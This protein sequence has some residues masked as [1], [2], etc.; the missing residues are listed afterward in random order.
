MDAPPPPVPPARPGGHQLRREVVLHHQRERILTAAVELIAERGYRAV[1]VADIVKRAA[2]ARAKFYAN[3]ASKQDCFFAAYDRALAEALHRVGE[4]SASAS[5][6]PAGVSAGL[7]ALLGYI[8][9]EPA[10]ARACLL[11]APSL[12]PAMATR[13]EAAQQGFAAL[14]RGGREAAVEAELPG[15][16]EESV[17]GGLYWLLYHAILAAQ[18]ERIEELRPEL[19]EFALTPFLGV[20]AAR[21]AAMS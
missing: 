21:E 20:E 17:L 2:I 9:A 1:T 8:A 7:G 18:P 14:L 5:S 19:V 12:G 16:V 4:A 3:F 11:E 13:G 6:F 15:G 10:L